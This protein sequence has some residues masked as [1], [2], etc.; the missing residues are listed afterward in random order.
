M[1]RQYIAK[2]SSL[3]VGVS[4]ILVMVG[5]SFD[6]AVLKSI[7]SDFVAMKFVTAICFFLSAISLYF[8]AKALE[9]EIEKAQIAL[10][11]TSLIIIM[12]M[13]TLFFSTIFGVRTG[14][15]ELFVREV[16]GTVKTIIPGFPSISTIF[17]FMLLVSASILT[18]LTAR[19]L[20]IKLT[21]LGLLIGIIGLLALVGYITNSPPLYYFIKGINTAMALNT[22]ILFILLGTGLLCL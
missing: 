20:R 3:I 15:E 22:S 19:N 12:L 14:I 8:I 21:V 1:R 17:S 10:S 13:G 2:I 18:M 4:S 5:W 7:S 16:P 6:I 11:I 9:G